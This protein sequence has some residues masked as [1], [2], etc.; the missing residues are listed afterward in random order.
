MSA[1]EIG[2]KI[3]R[4]RK[5]IYSVLSRIGLPFNG[6]KDTGRRLENPKT[7]AFETEVKWYYFSLGMSSKDIANITG[8]DMKTVYAALHRLGIPLRKQSRRS[9]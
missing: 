8:R 3:G 4:N 6:L 2:R 5:T 9:G 7:L 1:P